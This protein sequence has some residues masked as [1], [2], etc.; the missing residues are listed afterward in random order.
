MGIRR[1]DVTATD[2]AICRFMANSPIF[3]TEDMY[4]AEPN[5]HK[6]KVGEIRTLHGLESYPEHNGEQ[7]EITAIREDGHH[8]RCYYVKG[9]INEAITWVYEYRLR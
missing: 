1:I 4:K 7:V 8:G 5:G 9:A 2:P 6:F 3:T